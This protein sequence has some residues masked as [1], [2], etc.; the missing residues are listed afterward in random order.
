MNPRELAKLKGVT[1]YFTAREISEMQIRMLN[2]YMQRLKWA[3]D[4]ERSAK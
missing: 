4:L 1:E 2:D 3:A